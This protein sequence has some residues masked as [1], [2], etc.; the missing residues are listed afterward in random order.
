MHFDREDQ[1][2]TD[3]NHYAKSP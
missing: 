3:K 1:V 2:F